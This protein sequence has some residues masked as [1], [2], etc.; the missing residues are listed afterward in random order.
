MQPVDQ[1]ADVVRDVGLVQSLPAAVAG[2]DDLLEVFTHRDDHVVF[3]EWAMIEVIDGAHIVIGLHN[4]VGNL[5]QLFF[6]TNV[7]RHGSSL[8]G[9]D[10]Q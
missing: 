7:G 8:R 9:C 1:I 6:Q 4:A 2:V 10:D 5:R 3:R